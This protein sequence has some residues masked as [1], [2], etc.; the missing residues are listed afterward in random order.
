MN[1]K[2]VKLSEVIEKPLS[3]EWGEDGDDIFVLRST[4]FSNDGSLDLSNVIK[5]NISSSKVERKKL[6]IGD[7]IIE[8]SGGSPSQPVGR[9]VYFDIKSE[10]PYLCN[11]FTSILRPKNTI[12]PRYLF[13]F[14]FY[15]HIS[16]QTLRYQNKTTGIINL[17][18]QRYLNELDIPLPSLPIQQKIAAVLD[19]ADEL[20]KKNQQLLINYDRLIQGVFFVMFGNPMK[21][22]K[23]WDI[24]KIKDTAKQDK[25]SIKA[26]PF[27][28]SLKKE[29]YVKKGYKVYGQEQVIRDDLSYGNYYIDEKKYKEL[30]SCKVDTGDILISL[31]GTYG[32]ISIV[33]E[34]FEPGIINPR[35]MKITPDT[36]KVNPVY[37]KTLLVNESIRH[38]IE[39]VS[40]GGTM[41]IVN[42]GIMKDISIPLPPIALQNKFALIFKNIQQQ[43][44]QVKGQIQYSETLF[45]CLL[46]KAFKGQLIIK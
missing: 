34:K 41:D 13:W 18:T 11:N 38:Q 3:G 44:I 28:S 15:N 37:F 2:N 29:F 14:L 8:K 21:N 23:K 1:W 9:V 36:S 22:E 25:Y 24:K 4:N 45:D 6:L 35:L 5:R 26:G 42:V 40:R 12:D 20:R 39:N 31:V 19:S 30:E 7:T 33:P 10:E 27:G 46:N 16:K 17:Q 43:K 32:K